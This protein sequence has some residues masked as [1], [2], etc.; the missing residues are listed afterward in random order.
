VTFKP[1]TIA[2]IQRSFDAWKKRCARNIDNVAVFY[3]CGHGLQSDEQILLASDFGRYSNHFKGAFAFDTTRLGFYQCHPKTQCFFID[4]CREVTA[5]VVEDLGG[6]SAEPLIKPQAYKPWRCDHDL[7]LQSSAPF[8]GAF[9]PLDKVSYFTTALIAAL[10]GGAASPDEYGDWVIS[11]NGIASCIDE[12]MQ[13]A[14]GR[15]LPMDKK[16]GPTTVLY[17]LDNPPDVQLILECDP[18][19]AHTKATLSYQPTPP[20]RRM[21]VE[22]TPPASTIWSKTVK[23]GYYKIG[24]A[25]ADGTF[26]VETRTVLVAPPSSPHKLRAVAL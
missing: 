14:A 22:R 24:A 8:K 7:T 17:R 15:G 19:F 5:G 23:A 12:L 6:A 11:T 2:G 3:F 21:R 16:S 25:F 26:S 10:E 18:R 4:A 13:A 9:A 1:A 20:P